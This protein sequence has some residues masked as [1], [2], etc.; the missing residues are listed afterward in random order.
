M[1]TRPSASL[2]HITAEVRKYGQLLRYAAA[3]GKG[4]TLI[5]AVSLLSAPFAL[6]QP[7][8]MK[9]VLDH[10]LGPEGT[11]GPPTWA[12]RFLPGG[13]TAGGL[14]AWMVLAS[15]IIFGV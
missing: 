1:R 7:W 10:I 15:L 8:P 12:V 6:L 3:E 13:G 14:L 9:V 5:V 11:T 4:W 2:R